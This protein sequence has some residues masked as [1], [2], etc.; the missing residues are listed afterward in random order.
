MALRIAYA[1]Y[2]TAHFVVSA[3]IKVEM[4]QGNWHDLTCVVIV[5]IQFL[6]VIP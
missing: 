6:L 2:G 3:E 1:L 4:A 5:K